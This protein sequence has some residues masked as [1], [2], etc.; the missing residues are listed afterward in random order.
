M[1]IIITFFISFN[2]L[3]DISSKHVCS[4]RILKLRSLLILAMP[5]IPSE[6]ES[7]E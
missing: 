5:P 7:C 4:Q 2:E 3:F 6:A 1:I